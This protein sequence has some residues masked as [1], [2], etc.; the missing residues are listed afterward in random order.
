VAHHRAAVVRHH[1]RIDRDYPAGQRAE[2]PVLHEAAAPIGSTG[3]GG[4]AYAAV[5]K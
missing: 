4:D 2:F 5:M 3:P 1:R